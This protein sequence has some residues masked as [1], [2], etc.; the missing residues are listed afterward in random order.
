[1]DT[2]QTQRVRKFVH[3]HKHSMLGQQHS[4]VIPNLRKFPTKS[5]TLDHIPSRYKTTMLYNP[6][7]C[8]C[9][10]LSTH[11]SGDSQDCTRR[12]RSKSQHNSYHH[13]TLHHF[14]HMCVF[15]F[16]GS[17]W[18]RLHYANHHPRHLEPNYVERCVAPSARC[19]EGANFQHFFSRRKK[20]KQKDSRLA[21]RSY[22]ISQIHLETPHQKFLIVSPMAKELLQ[23]Q[24]HFDQMGCLTLMLLLHCQA[25]I[26]SPPASASCC[27]LGNLPATLGSC[28]EVS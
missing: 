6:H 2:V 19:A 28:N 10:R 11:A 4:H 25:L 27:C 3:H 24:D 9:S 22:S 15:C 20:A 1:M 23:C 26:Q 17:P 14:Q 18:H 7:I 21:G 5:A 13:K 16:G 12:C 8:Y